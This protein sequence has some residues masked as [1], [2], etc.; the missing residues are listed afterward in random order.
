MA[1]YL[2]ARQHLVDCFA[3]HSLTVN[4]INLADGHQCGTMMSICRRNGPPDLSTAA[5][6]NRVKQQ[7]PARRPW[8][9]PVERLRASPV[10]G[11]VPRFRAGGVVSLVGAQPQKPQ[12]PSDVESMMTL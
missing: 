9:S 1:P 3:R 4:C 7:P 5:A 11:R 2:A 6:S 8:S 10:Q 12:P